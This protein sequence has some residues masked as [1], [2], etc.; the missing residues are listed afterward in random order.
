MDSKKIITPRLVISIIIFFVVC[1]FGSVSDAASKSAVV[2]TGDNIVQS[3]LQLVA[4]ENDTH[5]CEF[6]IFYGSDIASAF[7]FPQSIFHYNAQKALSLSSLK[8]LIII[9]CCK[10]SF[11]PVFIAH[12]GVAS[13]EVQ[14]GFDGPFYLS[15]WLAYPQVPETSKTHVRYRVKSGTTGTIGVKIGNRGDYRFVAYENVHFIV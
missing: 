1:L 5:G 9:K 6:Q 4:V 13:G 15:M 3:S 2:A 14:E 8:D 12:G 10:G 7:V 11:L